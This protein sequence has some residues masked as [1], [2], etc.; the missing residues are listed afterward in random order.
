MQRLGSV[1]LLLVIG[2]AWGLSVPLM[3]VVVST[4]YRPLGLMAW[5]QTIMLALLGA[6][7]LLRDRAIPAW[8]G[9]LRLFLAVAVFG[10]LLP[11]YAS[12]AAAAALPAGIRGIIIALVPMFV[13]PLAILFRFERPDPRRA[14]GVLAGAVAVTLIG[15]PAAGVTPVVG[16]GMIL[17]ALVAPF[18]YAIEATYL[19]WRGQRGLDPFQLLAG[20]SAVGLVIAWP[21]AAA[22]GQLVLPRHIGAAEWALLA[23]GV[24]NALAYAGYVWLIASAG[25]VFASLVAYLVT[26]FGVVFSM[27]LL[28]ERYA[29]AVWLAFALMLGGLALIQ[30]RPAASERT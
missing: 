22:T 12:Y 29:P 9:S 16:V 24:L 4:G 28:G 2:A 20:A 6:I 15:L 8:R 18:S 10:A 26:G 19:A 11:G 13:L 3:T 1:A 27:L 30:P 7:I 23:S 21:L 14:A 17:V 25:S 5:T